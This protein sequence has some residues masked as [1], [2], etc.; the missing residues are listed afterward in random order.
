MRI[1]HVLEVWTGGIS[2]YVAPL[3]LHQLANG[4]D[5]FFVVPDQF[6][7]EL[8]ERGFA[9][10]SYRSSRKPRGVWSATIAVKEILAER[11]PDVIV[12]HST[13]AGIYTR[14]LG[15][16]LS[17]K[18]CYIP[19]GWSFLKRDSSLLS[20]KC[21][22]LVESFLS[23]RG[24]K[25]ICMSA[26]EM[27]EARRAHIPVQ[28]CKLIYTGIADKSAAL[29]REINGSPSKLKIGYFGRLDYQKGYDV[30]V[31][32]SHK[33]SS[34]V[35]VHVFGDVYYGSKSVKSG[36][37]FIHHGWL[38]ASEVDSAMRAVDV[39]IIPSRWEGFSLTPLEA[40]RA[41][42]MVIVTGDSSLSEVVINNF[43]GRI[44]PFLSEDYISD[45]VNSLTPKAC[46]ILGSNGRRV[47]EQCFTEA[48]FHSLMDDALNV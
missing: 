10:S 46:Q 14:L 30:L 48:R 43:N 19:H 31:N 45:V 27:H 13:F 44:V 36:N 7:D 1:A 21:F 42:K 11:K 2:T 32:A 12:A 15:D 3:A 26:Q 6:V 5:V 16:E 24:R 39:V 34:Q 35:E 4:H 22:K 9:A 40:M 18:V 25:V 17:K 47:F 20:R 28:K 23:K 8:R 33:F 37:N 41:A 29:E 38:K